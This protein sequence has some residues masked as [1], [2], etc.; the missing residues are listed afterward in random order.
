M[1]YYND[2]SYCI[3][4]TPLFNAAA[5]HDTGNNILMKAE[6][7][8]PLGSVKDRAAKYM[9]DGAE[10]NKKIKKGS[11]IVEP[12]SGNTGIALAA[13]CSLRG[14]KISL[15]MPSN[16]SIERQK[17]LK[18]FNSEIILTDPVAGMEGSVEKALDMIAKNQADYMPDQFSNKDNVLA[19]YETTGPEIYADTDEKI[20]IF[21]AGAG[22]GGTVAGA[23][24]Y[25]KEKKS[26]IKVIAVEP[27]ES[28]ILSG[29]KPSSSSH[30]I[31]GIGA[32][33][34]PEIL[35]LSIIDDVVAVPGEKALEYSRKAALLTGTLCGISSGAALYASLV[36]SERY[37]NEGLNIVCILPSTGERYLSTKLFD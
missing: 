32:G 6:F 5:L 27:E 4:N 17:L 13:L 20:D 14:Y 35:D 10:R 18:Y 12:T 30:I 16:M 1:K 9:L 22:T 15:V 36:V 26:S 3:G 34:V 28:S 8:N 7:I 37:K 29:N 11:R 33:F 2:V 19:H 23:G 24:K 25:L 31:Q 21:V